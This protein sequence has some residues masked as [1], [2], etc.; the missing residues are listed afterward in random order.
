ML[1][2][3]ICHEEHT[4]TQDENRWFI[5]GYDVGFLSSFY[6]QVCL[7]LPK[8]NICG[9][10]RNQGDRRV[11]LNVDDVGSSRARCSYCESMSRNEL[12]DILLGFDPNRQPPIT[13][14]SNAIRLLIDKLIASNSTLWCAIRMR[15]AI[16]SNAAISAHRHLSFRSQ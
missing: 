9:L 16:H 4:L 1:T 7:C 5:V 3:G 15:K 12:G 8:V 11:V 13:E 10:M 6:S 14:H 2:N